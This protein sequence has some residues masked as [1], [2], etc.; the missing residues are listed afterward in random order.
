MTMKKFISA[1]LVVAMAA[2]S[3]ADKQD[4]GITNNNDNNPVEQ[5]AGDGSRTFSADFAEPIAKA[6]PNYNE[7][8]HAVTVLWEQNDKVGVYAADGAPA[9]FTAQAPGAS[10]TLNGNII[11]ADTYYAMYPYDAEATIAAGQI[12]TALPA[13]QT[14]TADAFMAHLA[15][16]STSSSSFSF[17]NVCGLVR[18]YVGCEHV[19][20]IEFK[21]NADE[22]VA[23]A[24]TVNAATAEYAL[25]AEGGEK[26]ITVTPPADAATF[27]TGAYYFSVLPQ[28]FS[29]GF[30]VTYETADGFKE[31][32]QAGNVTIPR[33]S[34][35]V[36]KAF[37][38]IQGEGTVD[39]PFVIKTVH[40]LC[41]LSAVLSTGNPNYVKLAN[42]ID[43]SGVTTWTPINND[44]T[45]ENIKEIHFDGKNH[46]IS[47]F[48]PTSVTAG[49]GGDQA[50][51]F[52]ILYGSC[53]NLNIV[54]ANI[55][56]PTMSTTAVLAGS[57][58]YNGR[59]DLETNIENVHVSGSV[60]A[61]KVVAG[62]AANFKN[63]KFK[64][65]SADVDVKAADKH[66]GGFVARCDDAGCTAYFENCYA[67]GNVSSTGD[68]SSKA[69]SRFVGGFYGGNDKD[70]NMTF[71]NC[72]ATGNVEGDYQNGAFIAYLNGGTVTITDCYATGKVTYLAGGKSGRHIGG[73][74]GVTKG[75]LNIT[76]CYFAGSLVSGLGEAVGGVL[77]LAAANSEV[78][79]SNSFSI[80]DL[81]ATT[82]DVGGMIGDNKDSK[83]LTIENCYAS[84]TLTGANAGGMIGKNTKAA[85]IKGCKHFTNVELL[86]GSIIGTLTEEG[87]NAK[88][89]AE[90]AAN[91]ATASAIATQ[92]GWDGTTTWNLTGATP[93][94][95]CFEN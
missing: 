23:G 84:G 12:S 94:L 40:D 93:T 13:T 14:A 68:G 59:G 45:L 49:I 92:L 20:R 30:T 5:P 6:T 72:Y 38:D 17:M 39:D 73:I 60:T 22:T 15:V 54:G 19:T 55:D 25:A 36:G 47:N 44:R 27:E 34:L 53:S 82:T 77:G 2:A 29:Q 35:V 62:F 67:T 41:N 74:V 83:S 51:F 76:R 8:T 89:T 64:N 43:M 33:S 52:G 63:A 10:T 91:Y 78:T 16:A 57:V 81:T 3:C 28:K 88:L 50:S 70:A 87:T 46:T 90:E 18:V 56:Q 75:K 37:T 58:G 79:I 80:G 7:S 48:K 11:E 85:T 95:K 1:A 86:V 71:T 65:C 4:L 61:N 21:G 69:A 32:R 26:V 42:D 9:E 66:V 31:L 24:I